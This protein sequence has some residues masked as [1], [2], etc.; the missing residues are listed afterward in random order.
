[1]LIYEYI[2]C[3]LSLCNNFGVKLLLFYTAYEMKCYLTNV[4]C[5]VTS[6]FSGL[7]FEVASVPGNE[8]P[9]LVCIE[10]KSKAQ[11]RVCLSL[12]HSSAKRHCKVNV[13]CR[14]TNI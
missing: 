10:M 1:M 3:F 12:V 11:Y 6:F 9:L 2:I 8:D 7:S 4:D 14:K 5:P 13:S